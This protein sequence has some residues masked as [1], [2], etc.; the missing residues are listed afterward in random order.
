MNEEISYIKISELETY[1]FI[2]PSYQRGYR[3]TEN[4]I[5]Q[6]FCDIYKEDKEYY[7]QPLIINKN[8]DGN[9]TVIDG[10]QR[11][12]TVFIMVAAL[13]YVFEL[14]D[15]SCFS[16]SYE[17]RKFSEEFL[18]FL[19]ENLK[20]IEETEKKIVDEDTIWDY[21]KQS[22]ENSRV[23]NE[24][25]DFL[26]AKKKNLDFEH[27]MVAFCIIVNKYKNFQ[28]FDKDYFVSQL[29]KCK[30]IW[31]PL[32]IDGNEKVKEQEI[33][34]FSKI[35]T[36]KIPLTNAELI[37]VEI[38]NYKNFNI[39]DPRTVQNKQFTISDKWYF[40]EKELHKN[41]FWGFIPHKNQYHDY[42]YG[43][44]RI[45]YLFE[46][47]LFSQ[48]INNDIK[49]CKESINSDGCYDLYEKFKLF[50]K[51]GNYKIKLTDIEIFKRII[52][53]N[54]QFCDYEYSKLANL[55]DIFLLDEIVDESIK[56]YMKYIKKE[57]SYNL[58]NRVVKYMEEADCKS[59][60]L[61]SDIEE[62][63]A[64]LIDLYENDGRSIHYIG[65]IGLY[66]LL[67]L[68]VY[69]NNRQEDETTYLKNYALFYKILK[70]DRNN[71][72]HEIKR[73]IKNILFSD[74]NID[75]K[76]K[77][78]RYGDV[79]DELREIL[80]L[81]NII[82]L[83][84]SKGIGN[85]YNFLEHST[86][87]WTREHIFPQ[88]W[89]N[90]G[91]KEKLK[92]SQKEI[93]EAITSNLDRNGN[94]VLR[95]EIM[96]RYIN[97]LHGKE[98]SLR[99]NNGDLKKC[100]ICPIEK[101]D[102]PGI[103]NFEKDRKAIDEFISRYFKMDMGDKGGYAYDYCK[104]LV[105]IKKSSE[106]LEKINICEENEKLLHVIDNDNFIDDYKVN[107]VNHIK[108]NEHIFLEYEMEDHLNIIN[109]KDKDME[110]IL[111]NVNDVLDVFGIVPVGESHKLSELFYQINKIFEE[112]TD[113]IDD[114]NMISSKNKEIENP[115]K[116]LKAIFK[117]IYK[118]T[119]ENIEM[120]INNTKLI[121]EIIDNNIS[122]IN[123]EINSFFNGELDK[124]IEDN[125]IGNMTLLDYKVNGS[126]EI[127]NKLCSEKKLSIYQKAKQGE[128]IPLTTIL[129]FSDIYTKSKNTDN[130][131]M[132]ESRCEYL[133]D[134]LSTIN[135]FFN[136][137]N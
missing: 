35:N 103:I 88:S 121:K 91:G 59:E 48:V 36:G 102:N 96:L 78:M 86:K 108:G 132:F 73:E 14:E 98:T 27:M 34:Q 112:E 23:E 8:K 4:N 49:R 42:D 123:K 67:S 113:Q 21:W 109:F 54:N 63:F 1:K 47:L 60:G 65:D 104:K 130:Y 52:K 106:L 75:E 50:I 31:Y 82:V 120:F 61:W 71:R 29:L 90:Q 3:W 117:K 30:F 105:L 38:L 131:W 10:Q 28:R 80:L 124:L 62:I 77:A 111:K 2:I 13:K 44:T 85:R 55:F 37:K 81:Y 128:F 137:S 84:Q 76:I 134:I 46:F 6:L 20:K 95:D 41:D 118:Y 127:G 135:I 12:T 68:F 5:V 110:Q 72:V 56:E 119:I 66:N 43:N 32:E 101:R 97:L 53:G 7:L 40:I 99:G 107:V 89:K 24:N 33:E 51:S 116:K 17:N 70:T 87:V 93:L 126:P 15:L 57:D 92:R 19:K 129:T 69:Y 64:N 133:Q 16:L 125:S 122:S 22:C 136:R 9:W 100:T 45:D 79:N 39:Q 83:F 18:N 11:L 25:L 115:E 74:V 114:S 58:F 94:I 26:C